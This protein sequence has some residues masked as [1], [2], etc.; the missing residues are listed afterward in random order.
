MPDNDLNTRDDNWRDLLNLEDDKVTTLSDG[1]LD[2]VILDDWI[3]KDEDSI[4][5]MRFKLEEPAKVSFTV[6]ADTTAKYTIC[7]YANGEPEKIESDSLSKAKKKK[8]KDEDGDYYWVY[9]EKKYSATTKSFLLTS[10]DYFLEVK[11]QKDTK[12][13][14]YNVYL[15]G[16]SVFFGGMGD[17]NDNDWL[18]IHEDADPD[19]DYNL[20]MMSALPDDAL[21]EGW[22]G[23]GDEIAWRKFTL[24]KKAK[25]GF[26]VSSSDSTKFTLY[27]LN[28]DTQTL[29]KVLSAKPKEKKGGEYDLYVK[30]EDKLLDGGTYFLSVESTNFAKGGSADYSVY[31]AQDSIFY[32]PLGNN[33]D[34]S[35]EA[36]L[37]DAAYRLDMT[38][39]SWLDDWVGCGDECDYRVFSL[40]RAA[41][42]AFTIKASDAVQFTI[43]EFATDSK[44]RTYRKNVLSVSPGK[45][46]SKKS[47]DEYG[48]TI[49][50]YPNGKYSAK[51]SGKLFE[52]GK[53]Y[54][55]CVKSKNAEK[56]GSAEYTLELDKQK[57]TFFGSEDGSVDDWDDCKEVGAASKKLGYAHAL[58]SQGISGWVGYGDPRDYYRFSLGGKAKLKFEINASD[59]VKFTIYKLVGTKGNYSLKKVYSATTSKFQSTYGP[60]GW[61]DS[62]WAYIKTTSAIQLAKGE[63]YI[64]VQSTNAAKGG[65][66]T[67]EVNLVHEKS[68]F[69]G[70]TWTVYKTAY[71]PEQKA[72][73]DGW[74][75]WLSRTDETGEIITNKDVTDFSVRV[76]ESTEEI[77]VDKDVNFEY[78]GTVYHN[79][80]GQGDTCD[81]LNI[82]L[83]MATKLSLNIDGTDA[84]GFSI[85]WIGLDIYGEFNSNFR[86]FYSSELL[87]DPETGR[88]HLTMPAIQLDAGI[89]TISME[90]ASANCGGS[91]YYNITINQDDCT[92]IPSKADHSNDWDDLATNGANSE[93]I[94]DLGVNDKETVMLSGWVG[95]DDPVD[96]YKISF[97][98][99]TRFGSLS[100]QCS[101]QV[102]ITLNRLDQSSGEYKLSA[103]W[104]FP[105]STSRDNYKQEEKGGP[106]TGY[107]AIRNLVTE[108]PITAEAGDD[109]YIKVEGGANGG[110]YSV[111]IT[112]F[113]ETLYASDIL[114]DDM[115]D[116]SLNSQDDLNLWQHVDTD[117]LADAS[118]SSLA[119]LD[120][121]SAWQDLAT[122]A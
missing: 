84:A 82:Y 24:D 121:I 108:A 35:T 86:S 6:N 12:D 67:Y 25:L 101:Y 99:K 75:N 17:P 5:C 21:A 27:M 112:F 48:N 87:Q 59:P 91:A 94:C 26:M 115:S 60:D 40:D 55:I 71:G 109:Y 106:Y 81:Y 49:Y 20:G 107:K 34:D 98:G 9:P 4:D 85:G 53:D 116:G 63:Y 45:N 114:A 56:G 95:F 43:F 11:A 68:K 120:G 69:Y 28:T 57:S 39:W 110:D 66:A 97:D 62:I 37:N 10:G 2:N 64:C 47:K 1:Y 58:L 19:N 118:A 73:D 31:L 78:N 93:M 38:T 29:E 33:D 52:S 14:S 117:V 102:S 16:D 46:S 100:V 13:A 79:F 3:D 50:Y 74:N 72:P 119:D 111:L 51:I 8:V 122:L 77:I 22:V 42:F 89:Y 113:P 83:P 76:E 103:F 65:D 30:T 7:R 23:Y 61:T 80:V 44:G 18:V 90:S 41:R 88:F 96:Y 54:F 92:F 105:I 36:V 70:N 15:D 32:G 104:G